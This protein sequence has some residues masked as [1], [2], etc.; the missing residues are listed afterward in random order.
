MATENKI[1]DFHISMGRK[2]MSPEYFYSF[3]SGI[4][5]ISSEAAAYQY[6]KEKLGFK[7]FCTILADDESGWDNVWNECAWAP[8]YIQALQKADSLDPEKVTKVIEISKFS[9]LGREVRFGGKKQYGI[10]RQILV[11]YPTAKIVGGVLKVVG[12]Y[13]ASA[14]E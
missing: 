14:S 11:D 8:M 12:V 1:V 10:G 4:D 7:T 3:R 6:A 2:V 13:K 9:I 5:S